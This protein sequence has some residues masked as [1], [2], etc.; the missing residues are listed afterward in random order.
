MM[1]IVK[2]ASHSA[3]AVDILC[4]FMCSGSPEAI[5][6]WKRA[7]LRQFGNLH[8]RYSN[9]P[10]WHTGDSCDFLVRGVVEEHAT[11]MDKQGAEA[12][13]PLP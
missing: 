10:L 7:P 6:A 12:Y 11:R 4:L 9:P 8:G 13:L 5:L 1:F 2:V 3:L